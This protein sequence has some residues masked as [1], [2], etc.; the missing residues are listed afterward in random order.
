MEF[1]ADGGRVFTEEEAAAA[2]ESAGRVSL[3]SEIGPG[4]FETM[5]TRIIDGRGFDAGDGRGDETVMV[6]NAQLAETLWPGQNPIGRSLRLRSPDGEAYRVVGV[7]ETGKYRSIFEDPVA[8]V[9]LSAYQHDAELTTLVLRTSSDPARL[10]PAVRALLQELDD[11]LPVLETKSLDDLLAGR[12]LLAFRSGAS[13]G[14]VL[15]IGS[16]ALAIVGL[17]GVVTLGVQQRRREIGL[18]I[19]LGAARGTV[20]SMVLRQGWRPSRWAC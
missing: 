13:L 2:D 3:W 18:R 5:G 17:Y 4:Y 19:A 8:H 9:Y 6:I 14:G 1:N 7:V 10:A 20:T 12:A 11:R 16:L 15:G